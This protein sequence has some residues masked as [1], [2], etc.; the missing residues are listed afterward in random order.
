MRK[1]W[2]VASSFQGGGC[3]FNELLENTLDYPVV[4]VIMRSEES[5]SLHCLPWIPMHEYDNI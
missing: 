5:L 2:L 4:L 1:N 3:P